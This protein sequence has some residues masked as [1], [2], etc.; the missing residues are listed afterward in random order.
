MVDNQIEQVLSCQCKPTFVYSSK[1]SYRNH[2]HSQHHRIYEFEKQVKENN[3]KLEMNR[4][5]IEKLKREC[6]VWKDKYLEL[7][8]RVSFHNNDFLS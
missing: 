1:S 2:F 6:N 5:E 7:D 4:I 8:L 3:I